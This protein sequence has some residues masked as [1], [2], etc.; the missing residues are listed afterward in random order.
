MKISHFTYY[1]LNVSFSFIVIINDTY[2]DQTGS[3]SI[4]SELILL[5][6]F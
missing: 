1:W 2:K 5:F 6:K 4:L 3:D